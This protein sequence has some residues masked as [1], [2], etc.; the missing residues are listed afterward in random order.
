M[1]FR[2]SHSDD[3]TASR[4]VRHSRSDKSADRIRN[5]KEK[6]VAEYKSPRWEI[7]ERILRLLEQLVRI[8][9]GLR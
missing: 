9:G 6:A 8:F 5:E 7:V 1:D 3:L 2:A 4:I